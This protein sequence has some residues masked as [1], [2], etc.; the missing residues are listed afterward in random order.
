MLTV[1]QGIIV[2][3]MAGEIKVQDM[4]DVVHRLHQVK[5]T[6]KSV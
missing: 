4:A 5:G 3:L 6:L 1:T 2:F